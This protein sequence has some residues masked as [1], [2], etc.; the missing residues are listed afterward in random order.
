[1]IE[2]FKID[3]P[4]EKISKIYDKV[5]NY[6]GIVPIARYGSMVSRFSLSKR[7]M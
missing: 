2:K 7:N 1:M 6:P 5:K 3:I 4:K